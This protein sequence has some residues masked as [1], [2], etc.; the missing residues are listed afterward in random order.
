MLLLANMH[1]FGG[2]CFF[3]LISR[4]VRRGRHATQQSSPASCFVAVQGHCHVVVG[5]HSRTF[6]NREDMRFAQRAGHHVANP[7]NWSAFYSGGRA[8]GNDDTTVTGGV[9]NQDLSAT[10]NEGS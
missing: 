1:F 2:F 6:N 7:G 8:A 10:F 5:E 3:S 4:G 9:A